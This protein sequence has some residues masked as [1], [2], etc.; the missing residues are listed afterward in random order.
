VSSTQPTPQGGLGSLP[1]LALG[2]VTLASVL[3]LGRLYTTGRF[4]GTVIIGA[5]AS[6]V[7]AA[8]CRRLGR[9][10]ALSALI[11]LVALVLLSTWI[12]F[13]FT[14]GN[15][16]PTGLTWQTAIDDLR[17]AWTMF[18]TVSAPVAP[19]RGFVFATFVA[20][21]VSAFVADWAAFRVAAAFE[22]V[23]PTF[24]LFVF[25]ATLGT[26]DNRTF[27]TAFYLGAVLLFLLVHSADRRA[28]AAAWFASRVRGGP[29][30]LVRAGAA[31]AAGSV[32]IGLLA[33]PVLPWSDDPPVVDWH[34]D[35]DDGARVTVS[36]LVDVRKRLVQQS[37]VEV[38]SVKSARRA[39]WRLTSLDTFDGTIWGSRGSYRTADRNLD[40]GP[41]NTAEQER[42]VQEFTIGALQSPWLPAAFRPDGFRGPDGVTFDADSGSLLTE[43]DTA[44]GLTYLVRSALASFNPPALAGA[45]PDVPRPIRNKYLPLPAAFPPRVTELAQQ[46]TAGQTST[47]D[48]AMALQRFFRE[49]FTYNLDVEQPRDVNALEEFLFDSREGYCEQFAGSFAAMARSIGIPARVAVGFTPGELR[50]DGLF[51][52]TGRQAHAWPEVY[53]ADF[54]WVAFEPTPGRGAPGAE[55]YTGVPEQQDTSRGTVVTPTTTTPPTTAPGDTPNVTRPREDIDDPGSLDAGDLLRG[56]PS[57]W[58][59]RLRIGAIALGV[60]LIAWMIGVPAAYALQRAMR[61]RRAAAGGAPGLVSLAW[62]DAGGALALAGHPRHVAETPREYAARIERADQDLGGDALHDLAADVTTAA[63]APDGVPDDSVGSTLAARDAV[64]TAARRATPRRRRIWSWFDPRPLLPSRLPLSAN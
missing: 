55:E 46:V 18:G 22:A 33:A 60:V 64:V 58:P 23:I 29:R 10:V 20:V 57:P 14:V 25:A 13:P 2:T 43:R 37:D 44:D 45:P 24:T 11:S 16:L 15:G 62:D 49:G 30:V 42:I 54:G 52:V 40:N 21:W 4:A 1:A 9:G 39:Y 5:L 3:C 32:A 26:G 63:F 19:D 17:A 36:P 28:D 6:H 50:Q 38:F 35:D 31:V 12:I 51:H 47:Y 48:R 41:A 59:R 34:N 56:E 61:R 7:L 27:T 53:I 8:A